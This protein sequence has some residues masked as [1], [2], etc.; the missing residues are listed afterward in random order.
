MQLAL[1]GSEGIQAKVSDTP[2]SAAMFEEARFER[3]EE[4]ISWRRFLHFMIAV[5]ERSCGTG[6][7]D[8]NGSHD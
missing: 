6:D 8:P 7:C 1:F 5:S 4:E 2:A 3:L